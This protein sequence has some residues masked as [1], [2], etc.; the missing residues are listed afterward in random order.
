MRKRYACVMFIVSSLMFP[1]GAN[2]AYGPH[3]SAGS[4]KEVWEKYQRV[5][6][7]MTPKEVKGILGDEYRG[8]YNLNALTAI[9]DFAEGEQTTQSIVVR[10]S[11]SGHVYAK[12]LHEQ[13]ADN[14]KKTNDKAKGKGERK[15]KKR[16]PG[17]FTIS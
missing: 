17:T 1:L 15:E 3:A 16:E 10:F 14:E 4:P 2:N 6:I 8:V 13:E 7:G 9:W 12:E 11:S 5:K